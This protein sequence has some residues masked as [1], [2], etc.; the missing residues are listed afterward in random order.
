MSQPLL[1]LSNVTKSFGGLTAVND[2]SFSVQEREIKA[3]IGPNGAGK[4]TAFNLISGVLPPTSGSI[5]FKNHPIHNLSSHHVAGLGLT[6]SFQNVKLFSNLTVLENVLVGMHR[7]LRATFASAIFGGSQIRREE[8]LAREQAHAHLERVGL[9]HR[10]DVMA[11]DLPFGQ[12]RLL[13][14]ARALGTRPQMLLLD[15]PAAGLSSFEREHLAQLILDLREQGLTI[16]LVEHDI[17]L[18]MGISDS[19]VVLNYGKKL[20]E[21]SPQ[22]IQSDPEVIKAYLGEEET[23][24]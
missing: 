6:R 14:V 20:A 5:Q 19:L 1:V 2:L 16:L 11:C 18:V 13:E 17:E 8:R 4:T 21:G 9:G 15:E 7:H 10:A 22:E 23:A 24:C 12:Q 3:L